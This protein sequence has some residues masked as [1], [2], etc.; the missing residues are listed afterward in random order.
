MTGARRG[1]LRVGT[2]GYQYDHWRGRFYPDAL[3]KKGWF[4]WYAR[5]F[6]TVE[7]NNTFYRL[8]EPPVFDEW[9][10]VAPPGFRYALKYSRFATHMKKLKDPAEP[11]ERFLSRAG[12]LGPLL[13]P[14][15]VQL[16]PGWGPDVPRLDAFLAAAPRDVRWV[17]ELRDPRWLRDDVFATLAQYGAALCVHDLLPDHPRPVTADFVYLRFHGPNAGQA[18]YEGAYDPARLRAEA[19]WIARERDAGRDV[20]AFFNNDDRAFAVANALELRR[21]GQGG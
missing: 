13:G 12:R 20:W 3:A 11:L 1:D 15:L 6:D 8:P 7:I 18:H 2:S 9:R 5:H 10:A 16:P 19:A 17:I 21:L 4:G 14:V